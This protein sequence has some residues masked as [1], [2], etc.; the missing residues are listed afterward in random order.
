MSMPRVPAARP[1]SSVPLQHPPWNGSAKTTS[2]R[3][4]TAVVSTS[5]VPVN[6]DHSRPSR[7]PPSRRS[8]PT[9]QRATAAANA[10]QP[11]V[12]PATE[13]YQQHFLRSPD[14][15]EMARVHT[16]NINDNALVTPASIFQSFLSPNSEQPHFGPVI[17]DWAEEQCA[18]SSL[19]IDID[20]QLHQLQLRL[21][22]TRDMLRASAQSQVVAQDARRKA[23]KG[24]Q[25]GSG[26]LMRYTVRSDI[27]KKVASS[28]AAQDDD[29][30][31]LPDW[32]PPKLE[33]KFPWDD[34]AA[35]AT[36]AA[37]ERQPSAESGGGESH[38]R[39]G[40]T[41]SNAAEPSHRLQGAYHRYFGADTRSKINN[42][43]SMPSDPPPRHGMKRSTAAQKAAPAAATSRS[44]RGRSG[45]L[46]P[47]KENDSDAST[48]D[49]QQY[50][51]SILLRQQRRTNHAADMSAESIQD[52]VLYGANKHRPTTLLSP[53]RDEDHRHHSAAMFGSDDDKFFDDEDD[54]TLLLQQPA[55]DRSGFVAQ[56]DRHIGR[57]DNDLVSTPRGAHHRPFPNNASPQDPLK[58]ATTV[59]ETQPQQPTPQFPPHPVSHH[60]DGA[61]SASVASV[62]E[63]INFANSSHPVML[64]T[65]FLSSSYVWATTTT[66]GDGAHPHR[67]ASLRDEGEFVMA[68]DVMTMLR[69]E[70]MAKKKTIAID[71]PS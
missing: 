45:L 27:K 61:W 20:T 46:P 33:M 52:G 36:T 50:A 17:P 4:G 31:S 11:S 38:D 66:R 19:D 29:L 56:P 28:N 63:S 71:F 34:E 51:Q 6:S 39:E 26:G 25:G 58:R 64:P 7:T 42:P 9:N 23:A 8:T 16:T 15:F 53:P 12:E 59:M 37:A 54:Y 22:S 55:L 5:G 10:K 65:T 21:A 47:S 67:S 2:T 18:S 68:R 48:F 41:A 69:L 3:S 57:Q 1:S 32:A 60:P 49:P 13:S 70:K 14:A 62:L 44:I 35:L 30:M 24:Q 40:G 43:S